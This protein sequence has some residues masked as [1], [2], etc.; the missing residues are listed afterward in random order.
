MRHALLIGLT[1]DRRTAGR[2]FGSIL[3]ADQAIKHIKDAIA[4]NFCP[5]PRFPVVQAVALDSI[6]REHVFRPTAEEV[7]A[8]QPEA[9]VAGDDQLNAALALNERLTT[10]LEAEKANSAELTASLQSANDASARAVA[11]LGE[12]EE[13]AKASAARIAELEAQLAEKK[14]KK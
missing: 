2:V 6:M 11:A 3:P 14:G 1:R 12:A 13:A 4:R 8:F 7:A 5:D 9:P 10:D